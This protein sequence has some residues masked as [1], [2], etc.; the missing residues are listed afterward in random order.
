MT[1][2]VRQKGEGKALWFLG[3]HYE[4]RVSSQG[5][6]GQ[7]TVMEFTIPTGLPFGAPP[8]IH[9][10]ADEAVYV[11][12]GTAR[13][14]LQ[15]TGPLSFRSCKPLYVKSITASRPMVACLE[16][17]GPAGRIIPRRDSRCHGPLSDRSSE[18]LVRLSVVNRPRARQIG[19][20][21][22]VHEAR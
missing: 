1:S 8:H 18:R 9:H 22:M 21:Q 15:V 11:L 4:V 16:G 3:G 6:G 10:D 2:V 13:R 20:Q 17:S 12:G 5:S 19:C 14:A 7:L